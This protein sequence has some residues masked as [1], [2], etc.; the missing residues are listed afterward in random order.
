M[1]YSCGKGS[2]SETQFKE[3]DSLLQSAEDEQVSVTYSDELSDKV[4]QQYY[5][6]GDSPKSLHNKQHTKSSIPKANLISTIGT[7]VHSN[8]QN[9]CGSAK[10]NLHINH[11]EGSEKQQY[12]KTTHPPQKS[13][14]AAH[15]T[16][17]SK[18]DNSLKP[19]HHS[20]TR[21]S[22]QDDLPNVT[23][24]KASNHKNEPKIMPT[25]DSVAI[26][27]LVPLS[28]IS[29]SQP[30]QSI[31]HTKI[32]YETRRVLHDSISIHSSL[33]PKH[34]NFVSNET[35]DARSRWFYVGLELLLSPSDLEAIKEANN[36]EPDKCFM[37]MLKQ[38]LRKGTATW[39]S[40]IDALKS[41]KVNHLQLANSI[42]AKFCTVSPSKSVAC[43]T[44]DLALI[45]SRNEKSTE[46]KGCTFKC[47]CGNC[48]IEKYLKGECPNSSSETLFP[49]L[50][51]TNMTEAQRFMLGEKLMKETKII[52][53]EF[54][55]LVGSMRDSL[56]AKNDL[57]P[58]AIAIDLFG[59][60]PGETSTSSV[61]TTLTINND[62]TIDDIIIFLQQ[63]GYISFFN[64]H[65]VERLIQRYGESKD[66]EHL[67]T[68]AAN[69]QKFCQRS[70]FEVPQ[71]VFGEAVED[72]TAFA[73]K[74]MPNSFTIAKTPD[75]SSRAIKSSAVV[76]SSRTLNLSLNDARIV[77]M[78]IAK[79][80]NMENSW[81]LALLSVSRG[82]VELTFALSRVNMNEKVKPLLTCS[83]RASTSG[84]TDLEA[85]GIHILCGPPGK[86]VAT[87]TTNDS[88][89]LK[90][91]KPEYQGYNPHSCYCV[92]YRS[93]TDPKWGKWEEVT[94]ESSNEHVELS[95]LLSTE[96]VSNYVF[97]VKAVSRIGAGVESK[98]SDPIK[99]LN[100][101]LIH[102]IECM[103]YHVNILWYH[104]TQFLQTSL[105]DLKSPLNLEWKKGKNM[106]FEI[107]GYPQIAVIKERAYI[108]GGEATSDNAK[109]TVIVYDSQ[110]DTYA[111]LPHYTYQYFAMAIINNEL[112]LIG[113]EDA[114]TKE[115]T[116]TLGVWNEQSNQWTHPYPPMITACSKA[117][118]ITHHNKW[119]IVIGGL[120]NEGSLSRVEVL[121]ITL[122]KWYQSTPLPHPCYHL[123]QTTI[124]NVCYLL[125]GF[126][127]E[128]NPVSKKVFKAN[129]DDI[130]SQNHP[131]ALSSGP[132]FTL[133]WQTLSNTPGTLSTALSLSNGRVLLAVGG[134]KIIYHYQ[135]L[136]TSWVKTGEL[137]TA[138]SACA[139]SVLSGGK[140]LVAG[141]GSGHVQ[142]QIDIAQLF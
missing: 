101:R 9:D 80:L 11:S 102:I 78:K 121:D 50:D 12:E 74:I 7:A 91:T 22:A 65:I 73:V 43:D 119:L 56:N 113:G 117:S 135:P 94:T 134:G 31:C 85:E 75:N 99:L 108:G 137:P 19:K 17:Q 44:A 130:V 125:G 114:N 76:A 33:T 100:V 124:G 53:D 83:T 52:V 66:K 28:P 49:F 54:G 132:H 81:E 142:K 67:D 1:P 59:T 69:L 82:C 112:V 104:C 77:Q 88:I 87:S 129:I 70:V 105:S 35:W 34:L 18:L 48:T 95:G 32:S 24:K 79:A 118:A 123:S 115:N 15:I 131:Y 97:K 133:P 6:S 110:Q 3:T 39:K 141:G 45:S 86:P 23:I 40:L 41:K 120:G 63:N 116:N 25:V 71:H 127:G 140:M 68:Y 57:N 103:Q 10:P 96:K 4:S 30:A 72:S 90:W 37:D 42:A 136:T 89:S 92:L 21:I 14:A 27:T 26:S 29:D 98:E 51:H 55:D 62:T 60:T 128:G 138:R 61:R 58:K 20:E 111:T 107:W 2:E 122:G 47:L 38:W 46:V 5:D 93:V 16:P 13:K 106:P 109:C 84:L 126:A 64:Y 8:S 36:N 139:C